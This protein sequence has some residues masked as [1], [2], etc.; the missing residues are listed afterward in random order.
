MS[1]EDVIKIQKKLNKVMKTDL[2]FD[3]EYGPKTAAEVIRFQAKKGL[4]ADGIVG[5]KTAEALGFW[6]EG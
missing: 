6:W 1:G 4:T 2:T 5:K 3:G